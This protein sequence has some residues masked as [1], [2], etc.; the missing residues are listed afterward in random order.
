MTAPPHMYTPPC[1]IR[2]L[3][4]G[5]EQA[6]TSGTYPLSFGHITSF[7]LFAFCFFVF[8]TLLVGNL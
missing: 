5:K 1:E 3:F 6:Y 4:V 8:G 2:G 7:L